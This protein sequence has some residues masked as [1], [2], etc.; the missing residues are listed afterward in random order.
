MD[1]NN[2]AAA[3]SQRAALRRSQ[4]RAVFP[5]D[6]SLLE[7]NQDQ[8]APLV[9]PILL[10]LDDRA[11]ARFFS[12]WT[13]GQTTLGCLASMPALLE[14]AGPHSAMQTA[15]LAVAYADLALYERHGDRGAK[16]YQAY[17]TSLQRLQSELDDPNFAASDGYLATVLTVDAFE[18][19][20]L[21]EQSNIVADCRP[22]ASVYEPR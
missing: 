17:C 3:T 12:C 15:I 20:S 11:I 2:Q 21:P 22:L 19:C 6:A 16:A 8:T 18:V 5:L 4:R 14:V 13:E 10:S 9:P 1:Q 7:T